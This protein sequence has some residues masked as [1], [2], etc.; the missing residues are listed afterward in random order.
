MSSL[1]T[2]AFAFEPTLVFYGYALTKASLGGLPNLPKYTASFS[3]VNLEL[4]IR[5]ENGCFPA[6]TMPER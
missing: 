1:L 5:K 3:R 6:W 4:G 2:I